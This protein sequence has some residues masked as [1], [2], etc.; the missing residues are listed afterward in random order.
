MTTTLLGRFNR[1]AIAAT[2]A[3]LAA[4]AADIVLTPPAGDGVSI[5]D[6]SGATSH[7]RVAA[8]GSTTFAGSLVLSPSTPVNGN[9]FKGANRFLHDFGTENVFLGVRAGNFTM[10]GSANTVAGFQSLANNTTGGY[11]S[12][13]GEVALVANTTGHD[14][15]AVGAQA[16]LVNTTGSG[17]TAIGTY[18]L[19]ASNGS[20]NVAI[21]YA[22]GINLDAG[23]SNVH[24]ANTGT[25]AD[26]NTIRIGSTG[27]HT[28]AFLAGVRGAATASADAVPVLI[29]GEGQLVTSSASRQE[30]EANVGGG[31]GGVNVYTVT[32]P[33]PFVGAVPKVMVTPRMDLFGG[34]EVND[35]VVVTVRAVSLTQFK[36]NAYRVD[37]PGGAWSTNL[38]LAWRAWQ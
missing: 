23:T 2:L 15:V 7:L 24:I 14:N 20:G 28:R 27:T 26:T 37:A 17:N 12:A 11:N 8:D 19:Y 35:T 3:S 9:L 22:A 5:T 36:V 18:A 21:G 6:S 38:R 32:F 30:G 10:T 29:D 33:T 13:L 34:F 16:L 4:S 31:A 25:A 1:I